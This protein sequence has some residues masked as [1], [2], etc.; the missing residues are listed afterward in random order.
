MAQR[1]DPAGLARQA[2]DLIEEFNR[3]VLD[4]AGTL[5]APALSESIQAIKQLAERLPQAF[6]QTA[7]ALEMLATRGEVFMNNGQ[8][9]SA[10]VCE[11]AE[12]L[13]VAGS[14]G[15]L[16]AEDLARPASI[17]SSIRSR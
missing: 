16:L 4:H 15:E 11:T 13:R 14:T 12:Q 2:R 17:L 9:H 3:V 10:A 1:T 6:D 5:S 8:N 7:G